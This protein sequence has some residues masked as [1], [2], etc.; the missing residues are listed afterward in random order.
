MLDDPLWILEVRK[1]FDFG[2]PSTWDS[3]PPDLTHLSSD[4]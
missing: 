2:I 4:M 3:I 1:I